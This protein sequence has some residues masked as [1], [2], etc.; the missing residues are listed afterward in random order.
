MGTAWTIV[1]VILAAV[2]GAV[3][4]WLAARTRAAPSAGE[5]VP[6]LRDTLKALSADALRDNARTFLDMARSEVA[7]LHETA[8]HDME[9]R[10]K[11]VETVVAPLSEALRRYSEQT[12]AIERA[13]QQ[14]YGSVTQHLQGLAEAQQKLQSET[15]S[16]VK[17]LRTPQVR[18]RWG[19]ITLRRVVEL[20][21]L[22]EHCDFEEQESRG[23]DDGA[24]R[25]DLVV[26][27]PGGRCV[28]V[29][30]KA[31]LA[32]YL[33]AVEAPDDETRGKRLR[34]HARQVRD[35]AK[36]LGA[37]SYWEQ[38][39]PT[40]DFVVLFLPGEMF[41]AAAL[42]QDDGLI[43]FAMQ[44]GVVIAT[45]TTLIALLKAVAWGW[46]QDQVAENA[47]QISELGRTLHDRIAVLAGHF[48]A[49]RK[50]LDGAVRAY[51]DA[52][53]SFEARVLVSARR[54]KE[55]G[56]VPQGEIEPLERIDRTTRHAIAEDEDSGGNE[57]RNG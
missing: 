39:Q 46:R 16:L 26:R 9:V 34:D 31:P 21:G 35:H 12:D 29:D 38:F 52:V 14:A 50:T 7:A 41:F 27:L 42:Q 54:F 25:P 20:A 17:A 32:A 51:N 43:D 28:V 36:K 19:E 30:S 1:T 49:L 3:V 8:R 13:R 22:N 40:P 23:A 57:S 48:A 11:S 37:K 55:L 56:A 44:A 45:P 53:G 24:I 15:A 33:D 5:V 6:Q 4:G 10:Q 2:A 18:G 47:R